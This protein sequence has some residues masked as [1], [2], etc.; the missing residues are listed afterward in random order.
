MNAL[1]KIVLIQF[2]SLILTPLAS[3]ANL[4][5][6]ESQCYAERWPVVIMATHSVGYVMDKPGG[7]ITKH[8]LQNLP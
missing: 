6:A 3:P 5:P 2:V 1:K 4:E 8:E 7:E